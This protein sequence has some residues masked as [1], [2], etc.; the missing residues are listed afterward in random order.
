MITAD[1]IEYVP[2]K[3]ILWCIMNYDK[4]TNTASSRIGNKRHRVKRTECSKCEVKF[5]EDNHYKGSSYCKICNN[6]M[7]KEHR[8]VMKLKKAVNNE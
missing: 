7:M 3:A 6:K 8:L 5:T 1:S 2:L 4:L